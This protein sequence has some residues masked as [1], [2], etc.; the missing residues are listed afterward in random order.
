MLESP[1]T[2]VALDTTLSS[3][4][5]QA[6]TSKRESKQIREIE[7]REMISGMGP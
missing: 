2:Q 6:T 3:W 1:E 4:L 7:S 5:A